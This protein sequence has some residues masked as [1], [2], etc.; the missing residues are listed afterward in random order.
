MESKVCSLSQ[1]QPPGP[2]RRAIMAIACAR[3]GCVS[4]DAASSGTG[5]VLATSADRS[6]LDSGL[7]NAISQVYNLRSH[8]P[9]SDRFP[10]RRS[11]SLIRGASVMLWSMDSSNKMP[12]RLKHRYKGWLMLLLLP[13]IGLLFP[14]MYSGSIP[15]ILGFPSV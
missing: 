6:E 12:A 9:F 7:A 5:D 11:A 1:G 4:R 3:D 14:K 13:Y 15:V 8:V 2:R 10:V